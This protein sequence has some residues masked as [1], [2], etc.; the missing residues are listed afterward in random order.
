M[1]KRSPHNQQN[2]RNMYLGVGIGVV[3][4]V[5]MLLISRGSVVA[6]QSLSPTAYQNQFISNNTIHLLKD[7]RTPEEFAG[8]HIHGAV[9]IPLDVLESRLSE[10]P[11][12]QPIVVYCRSGNRS[13]QASQILAQAGHTNIYDMGGLN[14]WTAQ[15]FPVE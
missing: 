5:A 11:T 6:S 10:V 14:D 15:G 9:N 7:I 1:S 8:G 13:A 2:Q 3:L 4:I 12:D